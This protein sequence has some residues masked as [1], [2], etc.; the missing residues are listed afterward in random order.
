VDTGDVVLHKPTGERWVVAFVSGE[1]LSWLGWPEGFAKV[2]DCEL[3]ETAKPEVR[4]QLLERMA[5]MDGMDS[6]KTYARQR[7]KEVSVGL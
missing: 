6:R 4:Q 1:N 7:L 5:A 2:S 3:L